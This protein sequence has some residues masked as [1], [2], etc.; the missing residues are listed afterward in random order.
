MKPAFRA[1]AL[2]VSCLTSQ[3]LA[4]DDAIPDPEWLR[5]R[6]EKVRHAHHLP[7]LA[8]AIVVEDKVVAASAVGVR[9]WGSDVKATR[10][11][12]FHLGSVAKPLTAT[13]VARL[14]EQG[15]LRWDSTMEELFPELA[16][17]LNPAYRKVTVAQ[18][19]SH[20]SGMP[21]QPKTP[22]SVTDSRGSSIQ[23]KRYEYVKAA[24]ADAPET[25]PGTRV[26]YSGGGIIVASAVE[27]ITKKSYEE[28][29][30]T[31]VFEP[32]EMKHA[33]FGAMTAP[34]KIDAPW[35][36]QLQGDAPHVLTPDPTQVSQ[37]RAPVGRNVR[38]SVIDL[39]RFCASH[40]KPPKGFLTPESLL[41]LH[42]PVGKVDYGPGF[43]TSQAPWAEGLILWHSGSMGY[44]H[45]L[46]HV[47]PRERFATCVL[48]NIDGEGVGEAL[49]EVNRFLATKF[50]RKQL[51]L[52]ESNTRKS[53][54]RQHK[55]PDV[56]LDDLAATRA[57]TGFGQV[58]SGKNA[59]LGRIFLDGDFYSKG[60]GVHAVSE[61]V[62]PIK[63][64]Y[65]RFVALVGVDDQ[66]CGHGSVK[67]QV[68]VNGKV[69]ASSPMLRGGDP[70]WRVDVEI[71]DAKKGG[72]LRLVV[73]NGGDG[74]DW[75]L[76]DWAEAGFVVDSKK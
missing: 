64:N 32:L 71:R 23:E 15:D 52:K 2:L 76:V 17:T 63:P 22:E 68:Y 47:V 43:A 21:Y 5:E 25:P 57:S 6:L 60:V 26:I 10:D 27:R 53:N 8:A 34:D 29:M 30:Q 24:L 73:N 75:D 50:R 49:D 36:H 12:P 28:L 9:K 74:S 4:S 70:V 19:L 14:V 7:A 69:A 45:A 41:L 18:Q 46:V 42:S 11:D 37:A 20:S 66:Q 56:F 51:L 1:I 39:A 38:C 65:R 35:D 33:G 67:V 61:L 58:S 48:T 13:M 59:V 3:A 55:T 54:V 62:Y 31:L 44:N 16:G 40:I 72:E